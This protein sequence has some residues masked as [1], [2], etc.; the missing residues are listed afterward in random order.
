MLSISNYLINNKITD[1]NDYTGMFSGKNL[2]VIMLES[3]NEIIINEEYYPNFYKMYTEGWAFKNNYSPR[4]SCSTGNNEFS[5]MTG[6]YTIYNN[7][8][9]NVYKNNTYNTAIFNLF[10]EADYNTASMHN[11]TEAYYYRNKIHTN[12]GSDKYYGVQDLGIAYK[13]EYRNWSSDEDFMEV[14]MDIALEEYTDKPFMLWL[15]TVSSHQPY[16]VSSIEGDKYLDLFKDTDYPMDLKRYMSKL[17]TLDNSLG[18]LMNKLED[19]GILE[20]TVIVMY[21]DHYPYGLSNKTINKVLDYDLSDY[22]VERTPFVIYN[23]VSTS[24]SFEQYTSFI[25]ITPTVANLFGLDYDP[26]LYMGS[27]ILSDEYQSMVVYSDGSWKNEKAYYNASNGT[28]KY[29]SEEEYT[30]EEIKEI[31]NSITLKMQMSSSIIKNNFFKY[32]DEKIE[33]LERE[34]STMA[35]LG[36]DE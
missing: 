15:T 5:G 25:N 1:L 12:L 21:G 20:D 30:V 23:S 24:K 35:N 7:C 16:V 8:T 14:A 28:I 6:L 2:I 31:N 10:K 22:E 19:A 36:E 17:K 32:L 18:I 4:N 29:Y 11:Y 27:D 33:K 9:A 34:S 26:R 3:V 13:N